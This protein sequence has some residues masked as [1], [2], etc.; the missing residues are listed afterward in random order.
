MSQF[1]NKMTQNGKWESL[2]KV[3]LSKAPNFTSHISIKVFRNNE[4]FAIK[5][6]DICYF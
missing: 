6:Q 1:E 5:K 4:G 2:D 3:G